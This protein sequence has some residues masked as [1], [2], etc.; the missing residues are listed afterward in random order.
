MAAIFDESTLLGAF[1]TIASTI[2]IAELTDKDA[3]LLLAISTKVKPWTT[4]AAGTTAFAITTAI[5]V[6]VGYILTSVFP[7]YWIKI[8]GG[9]VMIFY[10]IYEYAKMNKEEEQKEIKQ[11]EKKI[12]ES[13]NKAFFRLFLSIISMLVI[14]DLAG[15]A[16]EVLTIVFVAHFQNALLVFVS[17][18]VAL[19]A[20][21]AVETT[22]GNRLGK[23]FSF[24][25]IRIFSLL[26][27]LIIGVIVISTTIFLS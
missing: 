5:I 14:L 2:F 8:V 25:R 21:S 22:I 9:A 3:L 6:S 4:F 18:V 26:I 23:L 24:E 13:K 7:V 1:A 27:F 16:T 10:A 15:D 12:E 17:C 20:A 19:S 11:E